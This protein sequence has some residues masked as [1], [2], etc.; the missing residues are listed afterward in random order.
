MGQRDP[1]LP[2]PPGCQ[3]AP[4]LSRTLTLLP[5]AGLRQKPSFL[6][7]RPDPS[8]PARGP[9]LR[10]AGPAAS[11]S[12]LSPRPGTSL[13]VPTAPSYCLCD[14]PKSRDLP[15][16]RGP[17]A[18]LAGPSAHP[19]PC[20][21]QAQPGLHG[22]PK[23][24]AGTDA[25]AETTCGRGVQSPLIRTDPAQEPHFQPRLLGPLLRQGVKKARRPRRRWK[26]RAC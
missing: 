4:V 20:E 15:R 12:S 13:L 21:A 10:D 2:C 7:S 14:P 16:G 9:A 24:S 23:G 1:C 3:A 11:H 22:C 26:C 19:P 6:I 8:A 5:P 17:R 18:E 25:T